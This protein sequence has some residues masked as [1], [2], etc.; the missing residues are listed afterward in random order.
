MQRELKGNDTIKGQI[1]IQS[2]IDEL[3]RMFKLL[4]ARYF[5][6]E[7]ERPVITIL[8]DSTSGAYGW[9][10][11]NK[12]WNSKDN[13]WFREIN[14]CAEYLNR[15]PELVITTLMHEMCHLWNIQQGVQDT[16]RKGTYHNAA[17]QDV[18]AA[19]GLI[20]SRHQTYGYCITTPSEAFTELV[21]QNCREGCFKL[22]RMKTYRDGTPKVTKPG[23]DGREKTV[24]RM[25]QSYRKYV[26]QNCG[27]IART[28]KDAQL[29]CGDCQT[30]MQPQNQP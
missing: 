13:A 24:T 17:F 2:A 26:C 6:G 30:A 19:R 28:T 5:G 12:V 21:T 16:S 11:V 25:R 20:V 8:T 9:I 29:I 18:A 3:Q 1:T 4:N 27:L 22:E 15:P 23:A 10:S 14:L 7:L